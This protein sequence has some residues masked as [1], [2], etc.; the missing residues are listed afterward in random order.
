MRLYILTAYIV[1]VAD[2]SLAILAKDLMASDRVVYER[3]AAIR[4]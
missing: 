1:K 3:A 2:F 4:L